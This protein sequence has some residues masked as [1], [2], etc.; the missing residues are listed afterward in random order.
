VSST[1][2]FLVLVLRRFTERQVKTHE[3][4][5]RLIFDT[6]SKSKR[7]TGC[8]NAE[9]QEH[10]FRLNHLRLLCSIP[11]FGKPDALVTEK[12]QL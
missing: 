3:G 12:E 11:K 4:L 9:G 1:K 6:A 5:K 2:V 7:I 8:G 10:S